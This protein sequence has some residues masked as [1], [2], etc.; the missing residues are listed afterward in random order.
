MESAT[1]PK[2]DTLPS[3]TWD[4]LPPRM[5]VLFITGGQKSGKWLATALAADSAAAIQLE[6][7]IGAAA[8]MARLRDDVFDVVLIGHEPD[9]LDALELLDAVH[10]GCGKEQPIIVLAVR[11]STKCRPSVTKPVPM[12]TCVSTRQ[13]RE[14]SFGR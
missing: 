13:P 14:P 2:S 12:P 7:S 10:A 5:R 4:G 6:E 11:A 8:G 9:S 1:N 3:G